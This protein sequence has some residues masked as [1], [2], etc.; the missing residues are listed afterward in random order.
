ML[1]EAGSPSGGQGEETGLG[2]RIERNGK[3]RI[4]AAMRFVA[5]P[6]SGTQHG[7]CIYGTRA[8]L[9]RDASCRTEL[10]DVSRQMGAAD[11]IRGMGSAGLSCATEPRDERRD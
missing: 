6:G 11:G 10:R 1:V 9:E 2:T 7:V 5:Q 3:E 4:D 8:G